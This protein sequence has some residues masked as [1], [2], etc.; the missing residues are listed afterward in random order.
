MVYLD[1]PEPFNFYNPDD[2]PHCRSRFQ[3][4][5]D[6]SGLSTETASKQVSNFLY[7]LGKEAESV[8]PSTNITQDDRKDYSKVL[9]K[10]TDFLNYVKT[11][12]EQTRF[13]RRNQQSGETIEQ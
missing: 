3:Q 6:A 5:R 9:K 13:N 2:W 8:V 12:Y 4:F 7:C 11:I 1:S 10:L